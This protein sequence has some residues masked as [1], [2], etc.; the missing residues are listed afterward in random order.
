MLRAARE[1]RY[2]A[3]LA[4]SNSRLTRRPAQWIE[5]I[6]LAN[7]GRI[8]IKT[9]ASGE[10]DLS[11]ANGRAMALTVAAWDA[12]EAEETAEK[13]ARAKKQ[14]A[15]QGLWRG[16]PR[17]FGFEADGTT[18]NEAEAQVI[19]EATTA[20]LAGRSLA[21]I[22]KELNDSGSRTTFHNQWSRHSL[23]DMLLR[24]RNAGLIHTGRVRKDEI[25]ILPGKAVWDPIINREQFDAI[26]GMLLDPLRRTSDNT[27][28]AWIGSGIYLC[29]RPTENGGTC[30]SVMRS[31][32]V[33][34][35]EK[36]MPA[37]KC[38][39]SDHL[40]ITAVKTDNHVRLAVAKIV[41]DP[42]VV[43]AMRAGEA[44][45]ARADR[46]RRKVLSVRLEQTE[47]DY[48]D[49][50]IDARRYKAKAEKITTE[51]EEIDARLADAAQQNAT[52]SVFSAK[53]PGSAFMGAPL[54][55]QRA[56]LRTVMRVEVLP[57]LSRGEAWNVKR[58][59][60][61]PIT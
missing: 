21:A 2:D 30:G 54:D 23:R 45:S 28:T 17:P 16:G 4:Y 25:T 14:K 22:V 7:T 1:G 3:I 44:D 52:S 32:S 10:H 18:Q 37:Y 48:D 41:R 60:L 53:D 29:G 49:D 56:V 33:K 9:V 50:L 55:V 57:V 20:V 36:R 59:R 31:F 27:K 46:E 5:L 61:S 35:A 39:E 19:R 43:A 11:T 38:M 26:S 51:I 40:S 12:R 47:A 15:E 24:P 13:V 58:L 6:D 34:R 42:L 8:R